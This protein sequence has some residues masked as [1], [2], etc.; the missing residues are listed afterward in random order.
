[1]D[2][3]DRRPTRQMAVQGIMWAAGG[4]M[5]R[6]G[7]AG[8]TTLA[9]T[10]LLTPREFGL[11]AIT[12]VI[13]ELIAHI[14]PIGFHDALIQRATLDQR[15]L[16]SAFW[17]VLVTSG[18][19][20]LAGVVFAPLVA[21][22][23]DAPALL[24]LWICLALAAVIRAVGTV[25]RAL[26]SRRMDFRTPVVA[27]IVGMGL[28]GVLA[29][30]L[31]LAGAGPWSLVA[32]VT[33]VNLVTTVFVWKRV[34]WRPRRQLS[35]PALR[36]FWK[37]AF[38]V[39]AFTFLAYIISNADDQLVGFRLG[40][41][42]LGYYALAYS[43]MAWPVRDV[44]GGVAVVLY[45]VFSRFQDDLPRLG[46]VYLESVQLAALFVFPMLGFLAVSAPVLVAWLLGQRW[47]PIVLTV[48]ILSLS[49]VRE[50]TLALNGQVYRALGRPDL[51]LLFEVCNAACYVVAFV[52]GVDFGIAGVA[53]FYAFVGVLL[54]PVS[55][56]MV[57]GLLRVSVQ[58]WCVSVGG[59]LVCSVFAVVVGGLAL[60]FLEFGRVGA[61]FVSGGAL[62]VVYGVLCWVVRPVALVRLVG[63][64]C[65]LMTTRNSQTQT[66]AHDSHLPPDC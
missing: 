37:F 44:L 16:D 62:L 2:T 43:F 64:V 17:S 50:A 31:A 14:I 36:F 1:M 57:L 54:H 51:H 10:H 45:P 25:P 39:S 61:L 58:R 59:V 52:V 48:Q 65:D 11:V 12:A 49:G 30:A 55:L 15:D 18:A 8:V 40:A 27:R 3:Y 22:W 23:F 32:H 42:P 7:L 24:P 60:R 4:S 53:F 9:L 5:A 38:S 20:A 13:Q 34:A 21:S 41:E 19:V 56:W 29:I 66:P 63:L 47:V 35:I 33:I 26:L 6:Y 28:G 46:A